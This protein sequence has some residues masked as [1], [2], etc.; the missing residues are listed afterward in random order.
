MIRR[1]LAGIV[2]LLLFLGGGFYLYLRSSLPQVEGRIIV[3]G[4]K[5]EVT[6]ARD[7]DGVPL[8][9][10]GD[11]E[12]AAFGLGFAHAQDRLFQME[13]M[14]RNGAGRLAELFGAQAVDT[15]RQM[16]TLGIYRLAEAEVPLLS[17]PVRRGLEAYAS[18]VNA[19]LA[20]RS[21]AL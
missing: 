21:G 5:S 7:S 16:R 18:G 14:R 4:L 15:D 3:R 12:D 2:L 20:S 11:D 8:I 1:I 17:E 10:A 19:F 9:T 13:L 6:I